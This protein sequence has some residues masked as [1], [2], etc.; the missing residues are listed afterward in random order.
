MNKF[1][2]THEIRTNPGEDLIFVPPCPRETAD[3]SLGLR[4]RSPNAR[5]RSPKTR[6]HV[7]I[8]THQRWRDTDREVLVRVKK[9]S[10]REAFNGTEPSPAG[11]VLLTNVHDDLLMRLSQFLTKWSSKIQSN[12]PVLPPL[13]PAASRRRVHGASWGGR[14]ECACVGILLLILYKSCRKF[15]RCFTQKLL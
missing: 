13:P 15:T 2:F 5:A 14:G 10:P 9:E 11:L 8:A 4:A 1:C 7:T 6:V 3:S 12:P